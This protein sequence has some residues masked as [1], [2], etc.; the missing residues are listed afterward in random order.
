MGEKMK[1]VRECREK[2]GL[3]QQDLAHKVGLSQ[4][5]ISQ[6]EIG[7]RVPNINVAREIAEALHESLDNI[8]FGKNI[9][10]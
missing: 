4:E 5:T 3:T 9:S 8:F 7:T 2:L 6:Y 10:K 1:H